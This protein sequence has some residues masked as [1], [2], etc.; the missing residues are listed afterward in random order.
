MVSRLAAA[1]SAWSL[2][3]EERRPALSPV[4][5]I[6]TPSQFIHSFASDEL[7]VIQLPSNVGDYAHLSHSGPFERHF[8][9]LTINT[10]A[11]DREYV[12]K[13]ELDPMT[14][15][16]LF[17]LWFGKHVRNH[18]PIVL[19]GGWM[20]PDM[21]SMHPNPYFAHAIYSGVHTKPLTRPCDWRSL[22]SLLPIIQELKAAGTDES[23]IMAAA[24]CYSEALRL[25]PLD[26]EIA[27][28]RLIQ[29]IECVSGK[30]QYTDEERF[31][32]DEQL[33]TYLKWLEQLDDE[34]GKRCAAFVKNRLYQV[35]RGVWLWL[36]KRIDGDFFTA[37]SYALADDNLKA[38]VSGAYT[39]RSKY[40]HGGAA[41]ADF[42]DPTDGRCGSLET[43]PDSFLEAC[44]DKDL[45]KTLAR[46]PS[47]L[48]L[49]RLVRYGL[50]KELSANIA[51]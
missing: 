46:C 24:K 32:H 25:L 36:D 28:F 49:E 19:D 8:Y 16:G 17:S 3:G 30:S 21:L 41:F 2:H 27:F 5:L 44:Q 45:R 33:W 13:L 38:C 40:V 39:L 37:E 14:V 10:C 4:F 20:L 47:F 9:A 34:T 51:M 22:E 26:R 11:T 43:I 31:S 42:I 12:R 48:G 6:S 50:T 1:R 23:P 29:A 7:S 18:G 35:A 15:V